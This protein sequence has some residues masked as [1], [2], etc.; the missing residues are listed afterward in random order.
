MGR[1]RHTIGV[2]AFIVLLGSTEKLWAESA[3]ETNFSIITAEDI[4]RE[5][6]A[7]V[8]DLLR[9][10]AGVDNSSGSI[11][12]RGVQ[13]VAVMLNGLP[14]TL[15]DLNQLNLDDIERIEILRGAA[16][17]RF[18]ANAMGG[19]IVV[20]THRGVAHPVLTLL[21]SST[22]SLGARF[23]GELALE[24]W[25]LGMTLKDE[26]ERSYRGTPAA[27]YPNQ[28]TVEDER[29][30]SKAAVLRANYQREA[31]K[32]GVELKQTDSLSHYGR[33]N[34]WQRYVV[35]STRI[36]ASTPLSS[37]VELEARAGR[38]NYDDLGLLDIGTS[39]DAAGLLRS[40]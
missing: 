30:R 19:A 22:G 26:N 21:G 14:S 16:S 3:P 37:G 17:A 39:T 36:N 4:R 28:I 31:S 13:G 8:S 12:M 40:S 23:G 15:S 11:T 10:R 6:P 27:P 33:P 7:S 35:T 38:E 2:L 1:S 24:S 29:N 20:T 5:H 32:F 34:W 25:R 9:T 18:G